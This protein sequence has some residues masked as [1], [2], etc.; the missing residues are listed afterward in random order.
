MA[1]RK[2]VL[3]NIVVALL[4]FILQYNSF[5]IFGSLNATPMFS[6]GFIIVLSMF[7]PEFNSFFL[8]L[9]FGIITDSVA[10]TAF[11]FN[12]IF[13]PLICLGVSLLSHYLFNNNIKSCTVISLLVSFSYFAVR[14]LIFYPS[15]NAKEIMTY[16]IKTDLPSAIITSVF[17]VLLYLFEKRAFKD[18]QPLR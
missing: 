16:L 15:V 9:L 3:I 8:G 5:N 4:T 11:G 10:T 13:M 18:V 17:S 1:K 2:Y 12:T 6:L 14:F 7:F